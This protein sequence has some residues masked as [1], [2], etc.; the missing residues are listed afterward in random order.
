MWS[1]VTSFFWGSTPTADESPAAPSRD[2]SC[3][4]VD[5]AD[6]PSDEIAALPHFAVAPA[7]ASADF[8]HLAG[9]YRKGLA[10]TSASSS[11]PSSTAAA[12]LCRICA[13]APPTLFAG[14]ELRAVFGDDANGSSSRSGNNNNNNNN[15]NRR[16]HQQRATTNVKLDDGND[17]AAHDSAS[18]SPQ[19][20]LDCFVLAF[21]ALALP[22]MAKQQRASNMAE[23]IAQIEASASAP[24]ASPAMIAASPPA[25]ASPPSPSAAAQQPQPQQTQLLM[26]ARC[27]FPCSHRAEW[28]PACGAATPWAATCHACACA[29]NGRQTAL[30]C[31]KAGRAHVVWS[32]EG[33]TF[34]NTLDT[35][36]CSMC[37]SVRAWRCPRCDAEQRSLRGSRGQR[38]CGRCGYRFTEMTATTIRNF[39]LDEAAVRDCDRAAHAR[40]RA[41]YSIDQRIAALASD[42]IRT[43]VAPSTLLRLDR[44][45]MDGDGNCAFRAIAFCLF[46]TAAAHMLVRRAVA[47]GLLARRDELLPWFAS[48]GAFAGYVALMQ[49]SGTWADEMSLR[50][51]AR[52]FGVHLHIV[53]SDDVHWHFHFAPFVVDVVDAAAAPKARPSGV[54]STRRNASRTSSLAD[55]ERPHIFIAYSAPVHYDA[56]VAVPLMSPAGSAAAATANQ[57]AA[58]AQSKSIASLLRDL[59]ENFV[60][61]EDEWVEA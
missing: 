17:D 34:V 3:C 58:E 21:R 6:W 10:A 18:D 59:A 35:P 11:S 46:G 36:D 44:R 14:P 52:V 31:P 33:C 51:A 54:F 48:P 24:A 47:L 30:V 41:A 32:C 8:R 60:K 42:K 2:G 61:E 26:C 56:L 15:N 45:A 5:S 28:C 27:R 22:E 9:R 12:A 43:V 55:D 49:Q 16:R 57:Q 39:G 19:L 25:P 37:K 38:D 20:C 23:L 13:S 40:E 7:L 50:V 1:Y 53:S 29:V 4:T